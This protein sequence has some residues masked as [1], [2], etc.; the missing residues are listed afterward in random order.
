MIVFLLLEA[1]APLSL[2]AGVRIGPFFLTWKGGKG[3][4]KLAR[5]NFFLGTS[6]GDTG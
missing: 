6:G 1:V 4:T 2:Q 3:G 5:M